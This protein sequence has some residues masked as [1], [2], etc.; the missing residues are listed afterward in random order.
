MTAYVNAALGRAC[1]AIIAAPSGS[2]KRT[3]HAQCYGIGGLIASGALDQA[4]AVA[5]LVEAARKMPAHRERWTGL[6]AKVGASVQRGL[7]SPRTLPEGRGASPLKEPQR[8]RQPVC[9]APP[10]ATTTADAMRV[11][12]PAIDPRG[13]AAVMAY[14]HGRR[15]ALGELA[16][17]VIRWHPRIGAMLALFRNVLTGEPQAISRTFLDREGKRLGRKFLGPVGGAAVML[18]PFD[19][20]THGLFI[21]EGVETCM[22]ARQ[23]NLRPVWALGSA[24]AVAAFPILGGVECLTL[25]KKVDDASAQA[26]AACAAR[27]HAAGREVFIN[28]PTSGK[29][30][31]DAIRVLGAS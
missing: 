4:L 30:L 5:Q 21:G 15:L 19:C 1:A 10:G 2:Q 11:W 25:L 24:G 23:L 14:L 9:G 22:A 27:W 12:T 6:E 7:G 3:L 16:D 29:D 26:C 17:R 8:P 20:V 13:I 28:W 31:N 18:D